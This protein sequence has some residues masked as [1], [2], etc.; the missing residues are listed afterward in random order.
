[1]CRADIFT[2]W[3]A[4]KA[5]KDGALAVSATTPSK[6]ELLSASRYKILQGATGSFVV[7]AAT[8]FWVTTTSRFPDPVLGGTWKLI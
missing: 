2:P 7:F 1:M 6:P 4:D 5:V 3:P 8:P